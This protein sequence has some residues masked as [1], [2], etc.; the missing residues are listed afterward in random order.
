MI[1]NIIISICINE[2][3]KANKSSLCTIHTVVI[4]NKTIVNRDNNYCV[5]IVRIRNMSTI[6]VLIS[7]A[8][9]SWSHSVSY[10]SW[11]NVLLRV[12]PL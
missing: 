11:L 6:I 8:S 3:L 9:D 1:H 12:L 2:L 5:C 7:C 4:E 10:I